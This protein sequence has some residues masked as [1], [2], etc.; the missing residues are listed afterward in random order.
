MYR[1]KQCGQSL[2]IRRV[3]APAFVCRIRPGMGLYD[4]WDAGTRCYYHLEVVAHQAE[5]QPGPLHFK[6]AAEAAQKSRA[7]CNLLAQLT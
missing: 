6:S 5:C 2:Y 4:F 7:L 3:A 1:I